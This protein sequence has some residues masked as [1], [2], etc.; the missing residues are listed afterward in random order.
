MEAEVQKLLSDLES[1]NINVFNDA[2]ARF[3]DQFNS[4]KDPWL[5]H[6]MVDYCLTNSQR[7]VEILVGVPEPHHKYLFDRLGEHIRGSSKVQALTLLGHVVKRQPSWLFKIVNHQ[8]MKD[9]LK[10]L[11]VPKVETDFVSVMSA[12]LVII[13]LLPMI[14]AY[15]KP[16]LD[17][18]FEVF[19]RLASWNTANP[20]KL[21]ASHLLHLQVTLYALFHRLYGMFP[22]NF[23]YYLRQ[24]YSSH[25]NL[26]VFVHTIKPM[27]GTVRMHPLLVT[28]SKDSETATARWKKMEHHDVIVECAKY[29]L[30]HGERQFQEPLP[31]HQGMISNL[32]LTGRS[33]VSSYSSQLANM[34]SEEIWSPSIECSNSIASES[35]PTS[36]PHTP[37][38]QG[39]VSN[40]TFP[41]QE[42]S[43]PPEAAVEA[44]PETTPIKDLRHV[45]RVTPI[46]SSV[47]RALNTFSTTERPRFRQAGSGTTPCHS[48]PSSPMKKEPSPFIFPGDSSSAFHQPI[49][50][51]K[52]DRMISERTQA[53]A[54]TDDLQK[55]GFNLGSN[56][57]VPP[58]S[59]LRVISSTW[60]P[61]DSPLTV[62]TQ[63]DHEVESTFLAQA[64]SSSINRKE[65][66]SVLIDY[67]HHPGHTEPI[68]DLEDCASSPCSSGGLHMPSSRS[69]M[70]FQ[71]Q[72]QRIRYYSQSNA[73][74]PQ[75]SS[76]GV[77]SSTSPQDGVA[78]SP[79]NRM[80]KVKSW[81]VLEKPSFGD[82]DVSSKSGKY[83][84]K[85]DWKKK[86]CGTVKKSM[87]EME[88]QTDQMLDQQ[89]PYEH[90][91]VNAFPMAF[92]PPPP[93]PIRAQDNILALEPSLGFRASDTALNKEPKFSINVIQNNYIKAVLQ[94]HDPK[95][96]NLS[97]LDYNN[98]DLK[99]CRENLFLTTL[100]LQF[101][102]HRREVH[103]ERNRR[104]LGKLR[105]NRALEEHNSALR[106]HVALL[107][108]EVEN[109]KKKLDTNREDHEVQK[110]RLQ[111][112]VS[113]WQEQ[114]DKLQQS[115]NDLTSR[116]N[117]LEQDLIQK[118]E[119]TAA[120]NK[121]LLSVKAR[122]LD[123]KNE[124]QTALIAASA[125][126]ELKKELESLQKEM[127]IAGEIATNYRDSAQQ[128]AN[129]RNEANHA[130]FAQ[131]AFHHQVAN[132]KQ[133]VDTQ[134]ST[135]EASKSRI[136]ELENILSKKDTIIQEQ[137]ELIERIK[138]QYH[139]Q[140]QAVEDKYNALKA[141]NLKQQEHTLEVHNRL[142]MAEELNKQRNKKLSLDED[143]IP[144][145]ISPKS[146]FR[147]FHSD[148][149][150]P[151]LSQ[152]VEPDED[153]TQ[154]PTPL[155]SQPSSS[156]HHFS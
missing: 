54:E 91:F 43:S 102:R 152:L 3:H 92:D 146:S 121:E 30:D 38:A 144:R 133:V 29:A 26:P 4:S 99:T 41:L 35:R 123:A 136:T 65:C 114:V 20:S 63:E 122:L 58:Q 126:K 140:L 124:L 135:I 59:P 46:N 108:K 155:D 125:G 96:N 80:R 17:D 5:A 61:P 24:V 83:K 2:K 79:S 94:C 25:E 113:Y 93:S 116:C 82:A 72:L 139:S 100:Q 71:R 119:K 110:S 28:A 37:I 47:V 66:D 36:I 117:N 33:G 95:H 101:E 156:M 74:P 12:L 51:K 42:G 127:M 8:L 21:S 89:M 7:C 11:K 44:T 132:L 73:Y 27:L 103:A 13:I 60:E 147:Q 129:I 49:F 34:V 128:L 40:V 68:D 151:N 84:E 149:P 90:L 97:G 109:I 55:Q 86:E 52:M 50:F 138:E 141:I 76:L 15:I 118:R 87:R 9:V 70:D 111:S 153:P 145:L 6:F 69:L 131:E 16:H 148:G 19:S 10:L 62:K 137:K 53:I 115:N 81:P 107:E 106:D 31:Y 134:G 22:C 150:L 23:L 39:F 75:L 45:P 105:N 48:E 154:R 32:S 88:T 143:L 142:D 77:S 1:N 18:V 78:F 112:S 56:N 67:V 120:E 14:P 85:S 57:L 130:K 98:Q 104:L 64:H